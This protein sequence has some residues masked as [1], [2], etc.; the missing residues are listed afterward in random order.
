MISLQQI[1]TNGITANVAI[2]GEGPPVLL[3]HGFPHTWRLWTHV[4]LG[5]APHH[6]VIAPDLRGLGATTRAED[7]HDAGN[8]AADAEGILDELG[9]AH[10]AVVGIDAG[11]PP[12]FLLGMRR[13]DRVERLVLMESLLG[14]LPGAGDFER[15]WW[16]GFHAVPGLAENV[17]TGHEGEYVDW[18]LDIGTQGRGVPSDIRDAF[19]EAYTGQEALRSAFAHY[20]AM[21]VSAQQVQEAVTTARLVVPTMAVGAH[22]VGTALERQ[23]R[24]IADDLT[25]HHIDDCGHIIPLDRPQALL[26][27]LAPFLTA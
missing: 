26:E 22:P 4:I 27:L 16:F 9:I 5:L 11:A 10:A 7:G 21:P 18:F 14:P 8:L 1:K 19:V 15:P 13:P 25:G 3:L 20:R 24:P 23:L 2:A 17:L 12:A 6:Q